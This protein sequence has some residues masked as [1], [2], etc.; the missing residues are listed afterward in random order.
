MMTQR[1]KYVYLSLTKKTCHLSEYVQSILY[2]QTSTPLDAYLYQHFI[3]LSLY[4]VQGS[5]TISGQNK[6]I[7]SVCPLS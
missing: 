2:I 1:V 7:I 4:Y 5:Q 6:L 3:I